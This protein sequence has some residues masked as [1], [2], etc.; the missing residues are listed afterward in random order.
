[1]GTYSSSYSPLFYP[2]YLYLPLRIP[3]SF[4]F[5]TTSLSA[6][7]FVPFSR[8]FLSIFPSLSHYPRLYVS[9]RIFPSFFILFFPSL[10]TLPRLMITCIFLRVYILPFFLFTFLPVLPSHFFSR[11]IINIFLFLSPYPRFYLPPLIPSSVFVIILLLYLF[12]LLYVFLWLLFRSCILI[13]RRLLFIIL[14]LLVCIL[15][16]PLYQFLLFH[17][18]RF[19]HFFSICF[20]ISFFFPSLWYLPI[21]SISSY[22]PTSIH[23]SFLPS[24]CSITL[25]HSHSRFLVTFPLLFLFFSSH[26]PFPSPFRSTASPL[27]PQP[28]PLPHPTSVFRN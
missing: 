21:S 3:P 9:P 28:P 25:F 16:S 1:M 12:F 27:L 2:P 18:L 24:T 8:R 14:L 11:C 20:T 15:H 10:C 7:H 4:F 17:F 19:L 26:L 13:L 22:L 5:N 23:L 6:L